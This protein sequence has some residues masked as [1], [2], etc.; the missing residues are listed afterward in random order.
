M[1]K[2]LSEL[3]NVLSQGDL[4]ILY[5]IYQFRCLTE[6]QIRQ[7]HP[8]HVSRL[9]DLLSLELIKTVDYHIDN[10]KVYFLTPFGVKAIRYFYK[11]PAN[12]Y[13][14]N[15]KVVKRGYFRASELELYPKNIHHQVSLNQ[16]VIDFQSLNLDIPWKYFDE[17]HAQYAS[18]RPD[19]II[20]VVDTDFFLEMDMGTESRKQLETKWENY[21]QFLNSREY[22]YREKQII[23]LFIVN[24]PKINQRIDLVKH[25][26]H[27]QLLDILEKGIEIYVGSH[28]DLLCLLKNRLIP[29]CKG[30]DP[31]TEK[32]RDL[33]CEHQFI[34]TDGEKLRDIFLGTT[35]SFYIHKVDEN[36]QLL[37]EGNRVQE[38]LVDDYF[39][40]PASV[41]SKIA[42]MEKNNSLFK[43]RFNRDIAYLIIGRNEQQ[44]FH[45]LRLA[46][47]L[48]VQHVFFTTY[49]R[50][51]TKPFHEAVFQFDR[52][53]NVYHFA[54]NALEERIY[55]S[56][57]LS[58]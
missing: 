47:L 51:K 10:K 25:T 26:I 53:G 6:N 15:K 14:A 19:G 56:N 55:E 21:R 11:L 20:S 39:F 42:Y 8:E 37:V 4:N 17:K 12:I 50:L 7:L 58:A 33:L 41:L 43:H 48:E 38:F 29:A 30:R 28:N 44:L 16:F 3:M 54:N 23:L 57:M 13:D 49:H 40:Q 34:V 36:N 18:I 22:A 24:S 52:M 27:T 5:S 45:D 31:Y 46:D 35:Y 1:R 9:H 2:S 32:I